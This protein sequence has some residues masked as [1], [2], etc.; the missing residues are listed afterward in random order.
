MR[1]QVNAPFYGFQNLGYEE[2]DHTDS[3][4]EE[5]QVKLNQDH[6]MGVLDSNTLTNGV[7]TS[8]QAVYG[9][10]PLEIIPYNNFSNGVDIQVSDSYNG[11]LIP[12]VGNNSGNCNVYY[13]TDDETDDEDMFEEDD[14]NSI[15]T[16]FNDRPNSNPYSNSSDSETDQ[17]QYYN[18][19]QLP[20]HIY[21]E[22]DEQLETEVEEE[23]EITDGTENP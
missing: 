1:R 10:Q 19:Q 9:M 7:D 14:S 23:G 11:L 8:S 13:R 6:Q 12:T 22:A 5:P 3:E 17:Y 20:G 18:I 21:Y 2:N 16:I 15:I 4:G